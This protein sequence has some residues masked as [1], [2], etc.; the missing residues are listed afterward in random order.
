MS[1]DEGELHPLEKLSDAQLLETLSRP[2]HSIHDT[3][4]R[5]LTEL[6][7]TARL[8]SE[9][10]EELLRLVKL[11][12]QYV[13]LRSQILVVLKQRGHDIESLLLSPQ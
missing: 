5:T 8:T 1:P 2:F 12:D 11:W 9:Q 7:K 13:L 6:S 3:H 4:L 10:D